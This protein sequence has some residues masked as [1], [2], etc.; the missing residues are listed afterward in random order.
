MPTTTHE[1]SGLIA[2]RALVDMERERQDREQAAAAAREAAS[3][4][5]REAAAATARAEAEAQTRAAAEAAEAARRA[6]ERRQHEERLRAAE[7]EGRLRA[8]QAAHLV[9]VQAE[10]DAR[11]PRSR[12]GAVG[13]WT[14]GAVGLVG[15]GLAVLLKATAVTTPAPV[16]APAGEDTSIRDARRAIADLRAGIH[17]I[18]REAEAD[19]R[20]LQDAIARVTAPAA[21]LPEPAAPAHP[22]PTARPTAKPVDKPV[23]GKPGGIK[24]CDTNDP[25][26]EDC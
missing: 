7:I 8:S 6:E 1:P 3:A 22:R 13:L 21:A 4:A 26:A 16:L 24:I 5:A 9:H 11:A 20:A 12:P 2:I 17:D 10:L 15:L 23:V 25:L 18:E 14:A 19:R